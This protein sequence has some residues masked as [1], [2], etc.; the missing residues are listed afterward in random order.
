MTCWRSSGKRFRSVLALYSFES[1]PLPCIETVSPFRNPASDSESD[2]SN[3]RDRWGL[4][5]EC[6]GEFPLSCFAFVVTRPGLEPGM[7][8]P[9]ASVL[10]IT[11]PGNLEAEPQ[12]GRHNLALS[13]LEFKPLGR[14]PE[15]TGTRFRLQIPYRRRRRRRFRFSISI[16]TR[17]GWLASCMKLT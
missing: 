14:A 1:L 6:C 17:T 7:E 5:P 3:C 8:A 10:P 13:H 12:S 2:S 16:S 4:L 11:P 9:K 15:K